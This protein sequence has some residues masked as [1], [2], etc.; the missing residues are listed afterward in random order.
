MHHLAP[1]KHSADV[2]GMQSPMCLVPVWLKGG[3]QCFSPDGISQ[4]TG[5]PK[6]GKVMGLHRRLGEGAGMGSSVVLTV[7][8]MHPSLAWTQT[9]RASILG[10]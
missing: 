5:I 4:D 1:C 3:T 10:N 6:R 9:L 8:T 2:S 7:S